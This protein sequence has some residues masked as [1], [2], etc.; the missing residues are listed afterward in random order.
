MKKYFFFAAAALLALAACSKVTPVELPD[1]EISFKVINYVNSTKADGQGT[2]ADEHL[3][4][5]NNLTNDFGVYAFMTND[6]PWAEWGTDN[7]LVVYMPGVQ[8]SPVQSAGTAW[9]PVSKY[10][11]PKKGLL[12]FAAWSPFAATPSSYAWDA[13]D[14]DEN[15]FSKVFTYTDFEV[16]SK[17]SGDADYVD[18]MI[19]DLAKNY[20]KQK[21]ADLVDADR[22]FA[23]N[24]VPMLFRHILTKLVFQFKEAAYPETYTTDPDGEDGP[25]KPTVDIDQSSITITEVKL[26]NFVAKNTYS[27]GAWTVNT[28]AGDGEYVLSNP[29]VLKPTNATGGENAKASAT[30]PMIL[31]QTLM[32]KS[33]ESYQAL[34]IK[35]NITTY[36]N[37]G[38]EVTEEDVEAT[39]P[40]YG[41]LIDN[42][43]PDVPVAYDNKFEMNKKIVFTVT[44]SP[45]ANDEIK[46]DPAV[47]PWETDI[48]GAIEVK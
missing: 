6:T 40:F 42:T 19:S 39:V 47:V 17:D 41:S 15:V 26:V 38:G 30:E 22:H 9:A 25:K 12:T 34:Y 16:A 35:Y 2:G 36:Y 31:P 37:E 20:T 29:D 7:D 44:I 46:F 23:D 48:T 13:D 4:A 11:W 8:V 14:D 10:Y 3:P 21:E 1:E 28:T 5:H 45:F 24:G 43:D 18:L 27:G 32:D 33:E